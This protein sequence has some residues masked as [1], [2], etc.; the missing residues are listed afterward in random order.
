M[1]PAPE[2]QQAKKVQVW[3]I[4]RENEQKAEA[5]FLALGNT[6]GGG[7]VA[8][9]GDTRKATAEIPA[10]GG[11]HRGEARDNFAGYR[12]CVTDQIGQMMD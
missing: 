3:H 7:C 10:S 12:I 5:L 2:M 11:F 9:W 6:G 8:A 1:K 4:R